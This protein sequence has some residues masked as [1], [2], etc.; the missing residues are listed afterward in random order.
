[1]VGLPAEI[2]RGGHY[3]S[4]M[5]AGIYHMAADIGP[6]SYNP[7]FGIRCVTPR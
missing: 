2:L 1:M 5:G 6:G 4:G 3:F 7:A